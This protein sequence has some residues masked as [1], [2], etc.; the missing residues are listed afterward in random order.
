[1][2]S[3][4]LKE[5]ELAFS[6]PEELKLETYE[7]I[8]QH[9]TFDILDLVIKFMPGRNG[10]GA[11]V[12]GFKYSISGHDDIVQQIEE[13]M[14]LIEELKRAYSRANRLFRNLDSAWNC[15]LDAHNPADFYEYQEL[16]PKMNNI[17]ERMATIEDPK[18]KA[19]VVT[20]YNRFHKL[21]P[22]CSNQLKIYNTFVIARTEK[23]LAMKVLMESGKYC[24]VQYSVTVQYSI[25]L[26]L[27]G[28]SD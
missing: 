12:E 26:L 11:I 15:M 10:I 14:S 6:L 13:Q 19:Q 9:A 3:K 5:K 20:M 1:M 18:I 23:D 24:I 28:V 4:G 25:I 8:L 2:N 17:E 16:L 7:R 22:T 21:A 27:I